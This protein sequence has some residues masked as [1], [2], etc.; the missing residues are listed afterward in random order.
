M[1]PEVCLSVANRTRVTTRR[2]L[3]LFENTSSTRALFK[4]YRPHPNIQKRSSGGRGER[5]RGSERGKRFVEAIGI[6]TSL[7]GHSCNSKLS[8]QS[9]SSSPKLLLFSQ[10]FSLL[11]SSL[12]STNLRFKPLSL[13]LNPQDGQPR[14]LHSAS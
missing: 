6:P 4:R 12:S 3:D 11:S 5:E 14:S 9:S 7:Q 8:S 10:G 1:D 2:L 13:T